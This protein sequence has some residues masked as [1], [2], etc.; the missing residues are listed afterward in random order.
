MA[1]WECGES[2]R[3]LD[4]NDVLGTGDGTRN[5]RE[6]CGEYRFAV[7]QLLEERCGETQ[8]P[9]VRIGCSV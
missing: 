7:S 8:V 2:E 9:W 6:L 4:S 3:S 5:W 1:V